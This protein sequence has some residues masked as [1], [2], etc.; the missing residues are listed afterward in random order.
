MRLVVTGANGGAVR[1]FS[2]TDPNARR[3][4]PRVKPGD[5]LTVIDRQVVVAHEGEVLARVEQG[6]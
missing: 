6:L 5:Y 1:A 2:V 4:L 3:E